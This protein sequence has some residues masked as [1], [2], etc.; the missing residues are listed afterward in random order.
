[1]ELDPADPSDFLAAAV[2]FANEKLWGT[3]TANLIVHPSLEKDGRF[4]AALEK[5]I[6]ELRYGTVALNQWSGVSCGLGSTPWGGHPS[7]TLDDI[8]SGR[9]W[10]HNTFMLEGV[11]KVVL[12]APFIVQPTPVWFTTHRTGLE[13]GPKLTRL[14]ATESWLKLPSLLV[15]ALRG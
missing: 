12:R 11:E 14:I 9:G 10:V 4:A 6:D 2:T 5:A 7:T 15:S 3:L 13:V 8:Q 1:M